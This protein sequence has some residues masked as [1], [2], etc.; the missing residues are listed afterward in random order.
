[1]QILVKLGG[2]LL[3]AD[4]RAELEA[5]A[6]DVQELSLAGHR[7]ILVHGGGP[8]LT[9]LMRKMGAEPRI[10]GGRRVTDDLALEALEMVVGGKLNIE[11]VSALRAAGISAVGLTG[12]SAGLILCEK[13]P[14]ARVGD[15]LVDFG[16]VGDV[17][18]VDTALLDL[19]LG[20]GHVPVIACVAADARGRPYNINADTVANRIA[21][22]MR[23]DRLLLITG[24]PGVLR[25]VRDPKSR[26]DR[27]SIAEGRKAI[28]DGV[29]QGGMIPKLEESFESLKRGVEQIH[30][31]GSLGPGDLLRAVEEPGSVGTAL[32]R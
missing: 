6:A 8:Q 14:P 32:I 12:V 4:K 13:R 22:Q 9:A 19:L 27:L 7:L 30:I 25:D 3:S 2:E 31:L 17:V 28:A 29:V 15:E 21:E 18:A 23:V 11:L 26:I 5:I 16:H 24:A 1:M 10:V 20:A